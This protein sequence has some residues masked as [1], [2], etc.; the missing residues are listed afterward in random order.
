[1]ASTQT[2][3]YVVKINFANKD[4]LQV[5]PG[6]GPTVADNIV[7]YRSTQGNIVPET[8]GSI[9]GIKKDWKTWKDLVNFQPNPDLDDYLGEDE[10]E[11]DKLSKKGDENT[12]MAKILHNVEEVISKKM[13]QS[14]TKADTGVI[15]KNKS[16]PP[17]TQTPTAE[18]IYATSPMGN[19]TGGLSQPGVSPIT[20]QPSSP[21]F[22]AFGG[23]MGGISQPVTPT[24]GPMGMNYRISGAQ[25]MPVFSGQGQYPPTTGPGQYP[26]TTGPGQYPS[27]T[28]PGQ[29]PPITSQ[30]QYPPTTGPG[31]YPP[32]TDPGQYPPTTSQGPY[33]PTTGPGQYPP[34]TDPGQ[35]PPTTSQGQYPPTTSQ[36]QYPPT[37]AQGQYPPT[38]S[39]GQYP[40]TT[41]Q[42]QYPPT[43]S[44]G[45]YPPTTAQGQYPPTTSQGQYP[46]TT[47][48]GQYP[49]TTS[50]GQY[51]PTTTPGQYPPTTSQGQYPPTTMQG[52]YPPTTGYGQY[53]PPTTGYGQYPPITTQGPIPSTGYGQYPPPTTGYGQ[54]PPT[55]GQGPIPSTGQG[56]YPPTYPPTSQ[57]PYPPS[58][59]QYPPNYYGPI[60]QHGP[61][62]PSPG[63]IPPT[64][65]AF[66]PTYPGYH[67]PTT[68]PY[69]PAPQGPYPYPGQYP[70]TYPGQFPPGPFIPPQ[71]HWYGGSCQYGPPFQQNPNYGGFQYGIQGANNNPGQ[72]QHGN[73]GGQQIN[74]GQ[75][76]NPE[77]QQGNQ[78]G[79]QGNQG[80]QQGN[81]GD[82]HGNPGNPGQG[83]HG[84]QGNG[85]RWN[86]RQAPERAE[87]TDTLPKSL[88]YNGTENWNAFKQKFVRY[89][90]V[91][92]WSPYECKDYLCWC[93]EGKAIEFF[94]TL[95]ERDATIRYEQIMTKMEKRFGFHEIPETA[96]VQLN[97]MKQYADESIEDWADRVLQ[98]A[99]KAFPELPDNY[100]YKQAINRICHGSYDREAGQYAV[101]LHLRTIEETIDKIKS[102]QFNHQAIYDRGK[103]EVREVRY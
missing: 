79:Q 12:K 76:G 49:P 82:Q 2:V 70:P 83:N 101:N 97:N 51:P 6:V 10:T 8:F 37:T 32:T 36:G 102:Y 54:Y 11:G 94:A 74:P 72:G 9:K 85:G 73:P 65:Q 86:R 77:G 62:T 48:Q 39:Q 38:T 50:Q 45:Q 67:P 68:G 4:S 3:Q 43:T 46:P 53:P 23:L 47:M 18:G 14:E 99:T 7:L 29:Y 100:M 21:N 90:L 42:G 24:T 17:P 93:L 13:Q 91:R 5:L 98:L 80:G 44:Q 78:G 25:G 58:P 81:Q 95:L 59:G 63:P 31:Q 26:P 55:T 15:H 16:N 96:Q 27:T 41:A 40:P 92:N 35:Y 64:S 34:T 71:Q 66:F 88:R 33:P 20:T 69:S 103:K 28:D 89:A 84:Y 75:Q 1:M 22:G 57:G 61:F 52:Q 87:R 60:P 30:G 56:Q 19:T